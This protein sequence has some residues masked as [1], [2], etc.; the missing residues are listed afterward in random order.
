M[1]TGGMCYVFLALFL[2][3]FRKMTATKQQL[4]TLGT[5]NEA[6][7]QRRAE[8]AGKAERAIS[9]VYYAHFLMI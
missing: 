6:C 5:A 4:L 8:L 9:S 3:F 2:L 1:T 7:T